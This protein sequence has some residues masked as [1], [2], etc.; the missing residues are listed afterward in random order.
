MQNQ[1]R[2]IIVAEIGIADGESKSAAVR[3]AIN[4]YSN[5]IYGAPPVLAIERLQLS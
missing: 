1:P 5:A 2:P 4:E 3:N